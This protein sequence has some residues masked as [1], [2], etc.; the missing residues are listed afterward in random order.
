MLRFRIFILSITNFLGKKNKYLIFL[1]IQQKLLQLYVFTFMFIKFVILRGKT[2]VFVF[3]YNKIITRACKWLYMVYKTMI[4]IIIMLN[5]MKNKEYIQKKNC[6]RQQKY[7]LNYRYTISFFCFFFETL[8]RC[9]LFRFISQ[10]ETFQLET[11][12]WSVIQL[13]L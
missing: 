3:C 1:H 8:I 10:F 2:K 13:R 6:K 5:K 9:L 4:I 11:Q 12:H 7:L